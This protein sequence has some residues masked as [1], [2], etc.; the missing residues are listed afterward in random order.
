MKKTFF[1]KENVMPDKP[2]TK[3]N[4]DIEKVPILKTDE[5]L[6]DESSPIISNM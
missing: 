3:E 6:R 5:I 4:T 1:A 2:E